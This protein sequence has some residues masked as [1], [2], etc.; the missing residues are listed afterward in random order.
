VAETSRGKKEVHVKPY[1]LPNGTRVGAH[2]R[3]TPRTAHG[4]APKRGRRK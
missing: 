4:R 1:T 3:S 2:Y